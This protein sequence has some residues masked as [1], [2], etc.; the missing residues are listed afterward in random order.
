MKVLPKNMIPKILPPRAEKMMTTMT[1]LLEALL[2][3]SYSLIFE[4]LCSAITNERNVQAR[5]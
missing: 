2:Q 3:A 1:M 4:A 5:K